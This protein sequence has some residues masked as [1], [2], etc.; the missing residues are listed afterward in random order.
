MK[1]LRTGILTIAGVIMLAPL[2]LLVVN[3]F[4]SQQDIME[5][6]FSFL[7][8]LSPSYLWDALTAPTYNVVRGYLVTAGFVIGVGLLCLIV[9]IPAAYVVARGLR[10]AHRVALMI[11]LAGLFIP[12]QVLVI[13][14][15]YVLRSINL[16]G[17][18]PGFLLFETTLTIPVS[19]FLFTGFIQTIPVQ[20]DEAARID[21]ASRLRILLQVIVPLMR[22]AIATVVV[23]NAVSVWADFVNPQIILGPASGIYTVT[24]GVYAAIGQF[25]TNF[26][27]VYP[28]LLLAIAPVFVFFVFMQ[29]HIISGLTSG[30]L[31]G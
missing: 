21:G 19:V 25:T 26:S 7:V 11:M 29:R 15:V 2:Y 6:P 17:T 31:K 10:R 23:L 1:V 12:S 24:T 14:V 28:N 22:P 5:R 20:L 3:S 16:M 8:D 18:V 27:A 13:P 4:K 9:T 30:A